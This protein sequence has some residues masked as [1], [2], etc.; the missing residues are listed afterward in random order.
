MKARLL[1][2]KYI[3]PTVEW[4]LTED[5][6]VYDFYLKHGKNSFKK[7]SELLQILEEHGFHNRGKKSIIMKLSNFQY[8]DEGIG[9]SHASKQS[10]SVHM[11]NKKTTI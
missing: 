3:Q 11:N 9:F 2:I 4:N 5:E 8:L 7:F 6:L 1:G 10:K